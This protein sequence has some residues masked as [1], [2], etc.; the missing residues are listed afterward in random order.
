[1]DGLGYTGQPQASMPNHP[2]DTLLTHLEASRN[3]LGRTKS[4]PILRVLAELSRSEFLEPV[5]L[6][7]FHEAL[8]FLRA[9]PPGPS[10]ISRVEELL[11]KFHQRVD[12]LRE[13]G[14]DMSAFDDFETAGLAG[15][16]MQDTLSFDVVRW[17]ARRVPGHVGI[18]WEHYEEDR[19]MGST[20]P[21]FI[22]LLEEDAD[23]EANIP[24]R[25]WL[26]AAHAKPRGITP[27]DF[28]HT[29]LP[30]LIR[31]FERLRANDRERAELYDSL[32]LPIRWKLGTLRLS[33]TLNW[34]RPRRFYYHSQP[35][36]TRRQVSL[37]HEL[38]RPAPRL[39]H[40]S[41][42]AGEAVLHNVREVMAVRYRELYGTTLG[43]PN[44]VV[45][46]DLGEGD[47]GRGVVFHLWNLLADRRL[48]LRAYVAGFTQKNGV[49][50]N[51]MEAIGLCDWFEVGFNTFY[52]FRHGE[53]AW[54]Y[55]QALRCLVRLTGATTISVH[56]YQ[57]GQNSEEAIESGAFWFYRKL[58]FRSGRADLEKLATR[59][60]QKIALD[61]HYRTPPSTLR[62]LADAHLFCALHR[63][64]PP[65]RKG[66]GTPSSHSV[67]ADFPSSIAT[68][69]SRAGAWDTFS[70][71]N[72]GLR[73]NHRM[74][75]EFGGDSKRIR[76]ASTQEVAS[77][78][79]TNPV[80]PNSAEQRTFENWALVLGLMPDLRRWPDRDKKEMVKI[81]RAQAGPDEMRYLRLTQEHP[82]LRDAI[83]R[84]NASPE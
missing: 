25:R 81:I 43:D 58:G 62:R 19:A 16:E 27:N 54:I 67:T 32:R 31:R 44:S 28:G 4:T 42:G 80:R 83:L 13:H 3:R 7:R 61:P 63:A 73:V 47:D 74:A 72:L 65:S 39:V 38:S 21:R 34:R 6:L 71:R 40:L 35:L 18:A 24:W 23:V 41:R 76:E 56:P 10:V 36:I 30:W 84:L 51:Y 17:L 53:S 48:P 57:I 26:A 75:E 68:D 1:M 9:F 59:E 5:S 64:V 22:P 45:R 66:R 69:G 79:A 37:H 50:I 77:A 15:T 55:A 11:N 49:P 46:A 12:R 2:L 29:D 78:L 33:R 14:V 60:E 70:V 8:L 82:R 52:T 20:W